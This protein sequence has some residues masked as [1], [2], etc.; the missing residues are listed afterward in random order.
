VESPPALEGVSETPT[1]PE[2]CAVKCPRE[3]LVEASQGNAIG[4][5]ILSRDRK[6]MNPRVPDARRLFLRKSTRPTVA[7]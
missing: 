2:P 4:P 3:D 1:G 6:R 5:A 7:R